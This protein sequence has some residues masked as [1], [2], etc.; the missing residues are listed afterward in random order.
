MRTIIGNGSRTTFRR[1]GDQGHLFLV[2]Q[3]STSLFVP[4]VSILFL[5]AIDALF[6]MYLLNHGA[7]EINPLMSYLLNV[8]PY[9]FYVLCV[10][11]FDY[12][13]RG[14]LSAPVQG[15]RGS[16]METELPCIPLHICMRLHCLNRLGIVFGLPRCLI[17]YRLT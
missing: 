13:I 5:S 16:E 6:T 8:G 14:F 9:A 3:Y 1:Q 12:H 4:I 7:N 11:V 10:Q 15:C 17:Q 2:D